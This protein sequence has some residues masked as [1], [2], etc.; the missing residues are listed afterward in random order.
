MRTVNVRIIFEGVG[1]RFNLTEQVLVS[2]SPLSNNLYGEAVTAPR[3]RRTVVLPELEV[4]MPPST[5]MLLK[6]EASGV[7]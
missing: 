2:D 1:G 6:L 3:D 5:V 4:D 7:V